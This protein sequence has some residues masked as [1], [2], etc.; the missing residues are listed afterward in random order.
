MSRRTV[1]IIECD[2]CGAEH[3]VP[4]ASR[5]FVASDAERVGWEPREWRDGDDRDL[6][7]DCAGTEGGDA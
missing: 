3:R 4:D 6:C 1:A 7:S 5:D 2:E